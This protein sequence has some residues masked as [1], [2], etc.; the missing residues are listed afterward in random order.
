MGLCTKAGVKQ[1]KKQKQKNLSFARAHMH[2][3]NYASFYMPG[4]AFL[5][6]LEHERR[7]RRV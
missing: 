5:R 7:L 3:L 6:D 2:E 4:G 1:R